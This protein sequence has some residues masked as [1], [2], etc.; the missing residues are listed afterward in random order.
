MQRV[1]GR[2]SAFVPAHFGQK[3]AS[4][5]NVSPRRQSITAASIFKYIDVLADL[6]NTLAENFGIL[7]DFMLIV[8][9]EALISS[10]VVLG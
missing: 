8:S 1:T 7:A 6:Y 4:E 3:R 2:V 9:G 10:E 5:V